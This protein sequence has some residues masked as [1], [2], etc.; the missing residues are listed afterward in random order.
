MRLNQ[1]SLLLFQQS[2]VSVQI[3]ERLQTPN[4]VLSYLPLSVRVLAPSSIVPPVMPMKSKNLTRLPLY[5]SL[6]IGAFIP[7]R[8]IDQ[9]SIV[10]DLSSSFCIFSL[11]HSSIHKNPILGVIS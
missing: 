3:A 9:G 7:Q 1:L 4:L 8:N 10:D 2:M 6:V 11:F 5:F